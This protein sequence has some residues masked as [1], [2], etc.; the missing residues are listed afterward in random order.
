M[1]FWMR[2]NSSSSK[3]SKSFSAGG[4]SA[5]EDRGSSNP[6]R[7]GSANQTADLMTYLLGSSHRSSFVAQRLAVLRRGLLHR[8]LRLALHQ[9]RPH[10]HLIALAD[11][12]VL[13]EELEVPGRVAV[14]APRG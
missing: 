4:S 1:A 9:H 11:L 8:L 2:A 6:S 7:Q 14:A 3:P 13:D 12:V 10:H 5:R